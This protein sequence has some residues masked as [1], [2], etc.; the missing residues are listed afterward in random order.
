MTPVVFMM[1]GLLLLA[2]VDA[3]AALDGLQLGYCWAS[4]H[5][6]S[7]AAAG[8]AS[9]IITCVANA[10]YLFMQGQRCNSFSNLA[11]VQVRHPPG[12]YQANLSVESLL[13]PS[14]LL[15][16]ISATC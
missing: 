12:H 1:M 5:C 11:W 10:S 8:H 14:Q 7:R 16:L 3:D 6:C 15:P 2:G 9:F 4:V 13:E